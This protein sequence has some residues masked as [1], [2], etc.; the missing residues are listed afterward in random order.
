MAEIKE[1]LNTE[2]SEECEKEKVSLREVVICR[3]DACGTDFFSGCV[4][5]ILS[6]LTPNY[7]TLLIFFRIYWDSKVSCG[8][9]VNEGQ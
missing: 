3:R 9:Y 4:N 5:S 6:I 1:I 8:H 7:G 2:D